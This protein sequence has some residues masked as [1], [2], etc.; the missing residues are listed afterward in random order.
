MTV[1][2]AGKTRDNAGITTYFAEII[3]GGRD[4]RRITIVDK[5]WNCPHPECP[6]HEEK[7]E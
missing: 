4:G 1:Y 5:P 7:P 6:K 3:G 2:V